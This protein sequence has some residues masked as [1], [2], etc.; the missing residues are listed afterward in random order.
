MTK[1]SKNYLIWGIIIVALIA[2]FV[3][4]KQKG[5]STSAT[6]LNPVS[7]ITHGHGLAVDVSDSTRLHIATHH[8]LLVLVNDK[9]LYRVGTSQDDYMGF[10]PHPTDPKIVFSSGHPRTGGNIGVQRSD[11][12]GFTWKSIS[13]GANGP[14]DFHAMA[15]S[16]A[17]PNLMYGWYQGALQRSQDGG[18]TWEIATRNI[19]Q[20]IQLVAN[21]I[22]ENVVYA[23]TPQGLLVSR[24]KGAEWSNASDDLQGGAVVALAIDPQDPA[25]MFSFSQQSGL[26]K[27]ADGG[28]T[29]EKINETFG[30]ETVLFIA[31]SKQQP[32]TVYTLTESNT[33]YKSTDGGNGWNKIR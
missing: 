28:T 2:G 5:S 32:D 4:F 18:T 31:I 16:A 7:A 30:G 13:R 12:S 10:S 3:W 25:K 24:N 17:N 15:I 20:I 23:A 29:W 21:P 33:I 9:D 6:I 22:D 1:Q 26:A 19:P 11:D 14:V 8:G 27:S